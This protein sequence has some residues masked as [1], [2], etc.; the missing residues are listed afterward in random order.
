M[1]LKCEYSCALPPVA[2]VQLHALN[3][4]LK[5]AQ[6]T[7]STY[8]TDGTLCSPLERARPL[9]TFDSRCR[10]RRRYHSGYV[11]RL[12]LISQIWWYT[13]TLWAPTRGQSP[14]AELL[15]GQ[16]NERRMRRWKMKNYET[17]AKERDGNVGVDG[18]GKLTWVVPCKCVCLI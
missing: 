15:Q 17:E 16:S 2:R 1:F 8:C 10:A 7:Q 4:E 5:I 14:S 11:T 6:S 12:K 13:L 18:G 9:W 3:D